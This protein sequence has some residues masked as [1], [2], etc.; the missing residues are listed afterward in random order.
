MLSTTFTSLSR[1]S[2]TTIPYLQSHQTNYSTYIISCASQHSC[3]QLNLERVHRRR[4]GGLRT[5]QKNDGIPIGRCD[6]GMGFR[7]RRDRRAGVLF[8]VEGAETRWREGFEG[9]GEVSERKED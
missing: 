9:Q 8:V 6:R 2:G 3:A 4:I 1:P 7:W 5:L